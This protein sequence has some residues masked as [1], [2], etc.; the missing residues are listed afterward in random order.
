MTTVSIY[1]R[2]GDHF[3]Q[4]VAVNFN[5]N[6]IAVGSPETDNI[7][8]V[9]AYLYDSANGTWNQIG[10]TIIGE[11]TGDFFGHSVSLNTAGNILAV[12]AQNNDGGGSNSGHVR[13]YYYDTNTN[14]W[15]QIGLDI[16]GEAYSN[17]TGYDHSLQLSNDGKKL[18]IG[19]YG[20]QFNVGHVRVF[21]L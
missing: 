12:S 6:V 10:Q 11:A 14:A 9:K 15:I 4:S 17:Y 20:N 19:A 13:V 2:Y 16:D 1:G 3:G 18:V 8:S 5:G 21:S 7:G